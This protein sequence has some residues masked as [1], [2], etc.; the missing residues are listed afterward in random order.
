MQAEGE[1]YPLTSPEN[2]VLM[3]ANDPMPGKKKLRKPHTNTEPI[4]SSAQ[5]SKQKEMTES[6]IDPPDVAD[7]EA[8]MNASMPILLTDAMNMSPPPNIMHV[9]VAHNTK[10][11]HYND[12]TVGEAACKRKKSMQKE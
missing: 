8:P 4:W 2:P 10:P 7:P 11:R 12:V 3:P 5:L 6:S 9:Y 1:R